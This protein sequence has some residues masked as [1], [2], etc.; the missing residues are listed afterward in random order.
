MWD[1]LGQLILEAAYEATLWAALENSRRGASNIVYLT[2]LG[3]G[4]FG[5]PGEWILN[6]MRRAL[7]LLRETDLDV[8]IVSFRQSSE[9]VAIFTKAYR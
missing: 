1:P 9:E 5:N 4:A 6:A 2:L 7:D 8:R 3:G